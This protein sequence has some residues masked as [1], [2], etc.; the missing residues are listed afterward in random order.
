M[1]SELIQTLA[2]PGFIHLSADGKFSL[3]ESE[4]VV[5]EICGE[6][7][8]LV[9]VNLFVVFLSSQMFQLLKTLCNTFANKKK[10]NLYLS[11]FSTVISSCKIPLPV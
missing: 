2:N 10:K 6:C 11:G 7:V 4:E 9:W 8:L 1:A 3:C 5:D